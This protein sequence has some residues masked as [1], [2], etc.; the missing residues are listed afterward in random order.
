[1]GGQGLGKSGYEAIVTEA[2]DFTY[3]VV[4]LG[5]QC[6]WTETHVLKQY[7]VL[8][9][10][11]VLPPRLEVAC[12]SALTLATRVKV[13]V[14]HLPQWWFLEFDSGCRNMVAMSHRSSAKWPCR[15]NLLGLQS[16]DGIPGLDMSSAMSLHSC[17]FLL[18]VS[19]AEAMHLRTGQ[20]RST[21]SCSGH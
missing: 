19:R 6:P 15:A 13:D 8:L 7:C 3:T 18:K 20:L 12:C 14:V 17:M 16:A 11:Q 5:G 9:D 10:R 2:D 21:T 1:M 4:A